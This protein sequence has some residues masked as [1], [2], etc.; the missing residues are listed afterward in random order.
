MLQDH[1]SV[2][3]HELQQQIISYIPAYPA[4][5]PQNSR[6]STQVVALNVQAH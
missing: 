1:G 5:T 3:Y 2:L 4:E 6:F